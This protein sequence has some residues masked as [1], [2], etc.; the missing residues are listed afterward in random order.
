MT[1]PPPL[2]ALD[3]MAPNHFY[4]TEDHDFTQYKKNTFELGTLKLGELVQVSKLKHF[5]GYQ[6]YLM[7]H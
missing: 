1:F 5:L 7:S 4:V 3:A 2:G 6:M